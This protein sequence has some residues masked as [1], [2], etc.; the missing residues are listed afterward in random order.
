MLN[1][2]SCL[3]YATQTRWHCVML[4]ICASVSLS[5]PVFL[6]CEND[7]LLGKVSNEPWHRGCRP[8]RI[9]AQAALAVSESVFFFTTE[10]AISHVPCCNNGVP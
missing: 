3:M 10:N 7:S 6:L 5:Q 2:H 8:C 9:S 4:E 1:V